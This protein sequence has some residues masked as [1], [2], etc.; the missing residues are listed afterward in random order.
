MVKNP[1]QDRSM[2]EM[3]VP[4]KIPNIQTVVINE[5]QEFQS[6]GIDQ[7]VNEIIEVFPKLP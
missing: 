5:R 3:Y 7:H 6:S 2:K 1:M 4:M